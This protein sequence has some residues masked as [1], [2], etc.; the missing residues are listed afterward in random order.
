MQ[1]I[2]TPDATCLDLRKPERF[3]VFFECHIEHLKK[4]LQLVKVLP[5]VKK[6]LEI[7][8]EK[9]PGERE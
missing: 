1:T 5:P 4:N 8:G 9:I 3:K 7:A 6:S 2:R